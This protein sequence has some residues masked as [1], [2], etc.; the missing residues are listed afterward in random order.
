MEFGVGKFEEM[1]DI[2]AGSGVC[3][4]VCIV[5]DDFHQGKTRGYRTQ[6][7]RNRYYG[8]GRCLDVCPN[9]GLTLM[10]D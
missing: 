10:G 8:C 5:R 7:E 9:D 3:G 6:L 2:A 1:G 4:D